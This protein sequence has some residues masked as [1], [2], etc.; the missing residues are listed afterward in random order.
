MLQIR[1][2]WIF[3]II[4]FVLLG[5]SVVEFQGMTFVYP[6]II[7]FAIS[8]YFVSRYFEEPK[9]VPTRT[10]Q[11]EEDESLKTLKKRYAKE[12][13]TKEEFEHMKREL[14]YLEVGREK[15]GYSIEELNKIN[16]SKWKNNNPVE[17]EFQ[18]QIREEIQAL[19]EAKG[20]EDKME[21]IMLNHGFKGK[22]IDENG[23]P[24][25]VCSHCSDKVKFKTREDYITHHF[26]VHS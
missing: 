20:D 18:K 8:L 11:E 10:V 16:E 12:E 19:R 24:Y 25:W 4:G 6:S 15:K 1:N 2:P 9:E 22:N 21:Q 3:L 23:E 5:V 26:Q 14:E 7:A 13:I 17:K